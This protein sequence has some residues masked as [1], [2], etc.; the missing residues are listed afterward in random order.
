MKWFVSLI[1]A[2]VTGVIAGSLSALWMGGMLPGGPAIGDGVNVDEWT[3]DWSIGS[4]SAN[5]YIRARIAKRGLLALTKEEAVYFTRAEDDEGSAPVESCTYE[6]SGGSFP[7]RW[8]SVT[9]YDADSRLPMNE[10]GALSFDATDAAELGSSENWRFTVSPVQGDVVDAQW[11][12]S[13]AAGRFDLTL[14]LY[15]PDDELLASPETVLSA[16]SV[17]RLSCDGDA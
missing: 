6:V 4:T 11:V 10:D 17:K 12:S 9:L 8:W 2:A 5:S 15:Q 1:S 7:A 13:K 14:R 3:S 16:P